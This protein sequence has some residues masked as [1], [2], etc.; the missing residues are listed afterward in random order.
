MSYVSDWNLEL[1]TTAVLEEKT[2][3]KQHFTR[4]RVPTVLRSFNE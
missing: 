3:P 4:L 2:S 1:H